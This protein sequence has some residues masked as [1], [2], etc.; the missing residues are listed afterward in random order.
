MLTPAERREKKLTKLV[1]EKGPDTL[2][3]VYKVR[4]VPFPLQGAF[5]CS[6]PTAIA[7]YPRRFMY[8][9]PPISRTMLPAQCSTCRI[10]K[11]CSDHS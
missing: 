4:A 10:E 8:Q 3:A 9:P 1:G 7:Q 2:V 6:C 5:M 11:L